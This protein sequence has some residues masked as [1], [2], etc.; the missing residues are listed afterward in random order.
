MS[1]YITV[2]VRFQSCD[3][4]ALEETWN[5]E[6]RGGVLSYPEKVMRLTE[7]G[8]YREYLKGSTGKQPSS[9]M[10]IV[11]NEVER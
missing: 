10:Y 9:Q 8:R 4:L 6:Q 11:Y 7:S 2:Q 1:S 3:N 5:V